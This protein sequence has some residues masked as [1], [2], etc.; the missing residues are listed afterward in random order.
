MRQS[1]RPS[2]GQL[3]PAVGDGGQDSVG[4]WPDMVEIC[5]HRL[6]LVDLC[7]TL[8]ICWP[9]L[10]NA[11]QDLVRR[12]RRG[13]IFRMCVEQLLGHFRVTSYSLPKSACPGRR[14]RRDLPEL[15]PPRSV[16]LLPLL[17][18]PSAGGRRALLQAL[19]G[20]AARPRP[21]CRR[22][23]ICPLGLGGFSICCAARVALRNDSRAHSRGMP[24]VVSQT[25]QVRPTSPEVDRI[26]AEFGRIGA[27]TDL[28]RPN[29]PKL[30]GT[31]DQPRPIKP[32]IGEFWAD[33]DGFWAA[34]D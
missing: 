16:L 10:A 24:A 7:H 5:Q 18:A 15:P 13:G 12:D 14:R 2:F 6:E 26:R 3:R 17:R 8:N 25:G 1:W 20:R 28:T 21:D 30:G 4:F 33:F 22:G 29:L 27:M 19:V 34:S 9:D 31:L 11:G 32:D 23:G